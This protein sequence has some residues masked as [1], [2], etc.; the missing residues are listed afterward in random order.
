MI[1]HTKVIIAAS[2]TCRRHVNEF[3]P[4]ITSLDSAGL[5]V[6]ALTTANGLQPSAFGGDSS[7][8]SRSGDTRSL[9][10][11]GQSLIRKMH[12]RSLSPDLPSQRYTKMVYTMRPISPS[13][14]RK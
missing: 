8:V 6:E 14:N 3:L 5:L 7:A 11:A 4:S 12:G 13:P 2:R 10:R 9:L 1:A